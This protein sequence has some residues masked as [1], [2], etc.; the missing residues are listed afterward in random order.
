MVELDESLF[1]EICVVCHACQH[2]LPVPAGLNAAEAAWMH[3]PECS[4]AEIV[5]STA[6]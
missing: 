4:A 5:D 2:E 6:A 1:P 3:E